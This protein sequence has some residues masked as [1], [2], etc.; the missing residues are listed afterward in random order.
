MCLC[1]Q[2]LGWDNDEDVSYLVLQLRQ[3]EK[4]KLRIAQKGLSQTLSPTGKACWVFTGNLRGLPSTHHQSLDWA[5]AHSIDCNVLGSGCCRCWVQCFISFCSADGEVSMLHP[6][7][8][9][10][11]ALYFEDTPEYPL[12]SRDRGWVPASIHG[13]SSFGTQ[14]FPRWCFQDWN[15]RTSIMPCPAVDK[16]RT[17]SGEKQLKTIN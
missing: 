16:L 11:Q 15:L 5:Q 9:S 12:L 6:D 13:I 17:S 2:Q 3:W 7:L 1:L 8:V 10:H 14:G 4:D